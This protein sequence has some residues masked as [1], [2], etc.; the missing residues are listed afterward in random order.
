M[1]GNGG[2]SECYDGNHFANTCISDQHMY[3]LNLHNI[4]HQLYL[5]R[6]GGI[7]GPKF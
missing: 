1:Q 7:A 3:T 6:G 4:L 5:N 2:V